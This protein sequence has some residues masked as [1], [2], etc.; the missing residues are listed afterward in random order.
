MYVYTYTH[1]PN[2]TPCDKGIPKT[3]H[4]KGQKDL[5][6]VAERVNAERAPALSRKFSET[7]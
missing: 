7:E 6:G 3:F 5:F 2:Q 4:S 1:S